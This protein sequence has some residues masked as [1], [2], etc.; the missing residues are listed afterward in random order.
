MLVLLF[1]V[2]LY[3]SL[4]L[5][6]FAQFLLLQSGPAWPSKQTNKQTS[7]DSKGEI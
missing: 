4:D 2:S 1:V 6:V 7:N 5:I 3:L